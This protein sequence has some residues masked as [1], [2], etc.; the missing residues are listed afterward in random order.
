MWE[1]PQLHMYQPTL[2]RSLSSALLR[3][4]SELAVHLSLAML[5]RKLTRHADPAA[6]S[7]PVVS[8]PAEVRCEDSAAAAAVGAATS[9]RG[10][11]VAACPIERC[12]C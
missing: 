3:D 2:T 8:E 7:S 11:F 5:S 6:I 12:V 4:S 1:H 10:D 9:F